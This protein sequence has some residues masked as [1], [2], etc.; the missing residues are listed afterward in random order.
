ML[1]HSLLPDDKTKL[2]QLKRVKKVTCLLVNFLSPFKNFQSTYIQKIK[3]S[4]LKYHLGPSL[5]YHLQ[6]T[7]GSFLNHFHLQIASKSGSK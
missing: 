6:W 3:S 1:F 7:M 4:A 5:M 2:N